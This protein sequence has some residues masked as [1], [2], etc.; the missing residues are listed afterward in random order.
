MD[1][2]MG[3]DALMRKF[4]LTQEQAARQI[5]K[6]RAAVANAV[7]LLNLPPSAQGLL[8]QGIITAGHA[9]ALLSLKDEGAIQDMLIRIVEQ[10]LT[11]RQVEDLT[12]EMLEG[13]VTPRKTTRNAN[14]DDMLRAQLKKTAEKAGAALGRRV[15]IRPGD[16]GK[17]KITL[18]YDGAS[19]L[20]A[21]LVALC[22]KDFTLDL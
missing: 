13:G 10:D 8:R 3:Y 18:E 17:G 14:R 20:E 6:S 19:D 11:V 22:G 7:R 4:N 16:K 9:R 15:S 21:L 5:G 2:A 1:E 12:R